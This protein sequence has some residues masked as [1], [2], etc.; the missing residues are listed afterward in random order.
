MKSYRNR[1]E[2]YRVVLE[3]LSSG[4]GTIFTAKVVGGNGE[5]LSTGWAKCHPSDKNDDTIGFAMAQ[6][7][8]LSSLSRRLL[9]QA[10]GEV[11]HHD[12]M[13]TRKAR[14]V[15]EVSVKASLVSQ[16][17]DKTPQTAEVVSA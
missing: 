14:R 1:T 12:N 16:P 6:S 11:L 15:S 5:V 8:A 9:K 7:R 4:S 13:K 2:R 10:N 3:K 17:K